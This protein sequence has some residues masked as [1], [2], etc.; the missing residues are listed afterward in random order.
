LSSGLVLNIDPGQ[1][2]VPSQNNTGTTLC[3]SDA[4]EQV[5][6]APADPT[7]PRID[8]VICQP[9]AA[10]LDGG[11]NNDFIFTSVT[12]APAPAPTVPAIPA[13]TV[14]LAQVPVGA[15]A[16]TAGAITDVRPGNLQPPP[17][18]ALAY[19]FMQPTAQAVWTINHN[20][21]FI[22]EVTVV[23]SSGREVIGEVTYPSSTTVQVVFSAAFAGDAY[24]S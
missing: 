20:L 17:Q 23:D 13:G 10:D 11:L 18:P 14:G 19:H 1:V 12:G 16:A 24:L 8:V 22:P 7:N 4:V 6:L 2:A 15:A 3:T 5:T 21:S 9:R